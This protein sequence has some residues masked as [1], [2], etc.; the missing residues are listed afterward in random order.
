MIVNILAVGDVFG[1]NGLN[2]LERKL[3]TI[4]KFKDISFTVVNGENSSVVG[5][6]PKQAEAIFNAGA[7]VITLGNHT[8]NRQNII[9]YLDDNRY[10]IRPANLS[11]QTPG[12]GWGVFDSSFGDVCVINLIGRCGMDFGPDNPFYCADRILKNVDTKVVLIDM[13]AEATSEKAAIAWHLDG[14]I[15]ALWGTHTHVQTS[16]ATVLP[17]GTGFI[18]DLGMTGPALSILGVKPEMSINRF[19]GDPR[20]RAYEQAPG[21]CKM[22]GAI[23]QV[24]TS[25]GK[26]LSVEA[27]RIE[28]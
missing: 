24:D 19:L 3:R 5:I 4:K 26:C 6:T 1:E 23:F 27:I 15:S 10:I 13:H 16:D 20:R 12:R 17:K 11:P 18:T 28:E 25:N 14:R 7:D 8:F 2:F 21:P 9:P 22:E